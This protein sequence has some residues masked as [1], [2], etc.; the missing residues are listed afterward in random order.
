MGPMVDY[1]RESAWVTTM[2]KSMPKQWYMDSACTR[3]MTPNRSIFKTFDPT[4]VRPIELADGTEI[5]SAG[6]GIIHATLLKSANG[7]KL[8]LKNV[9]YVPDLSSNLIS[10]SQLELLGI[11]THF[12]LGGKLDILRGGERIGMG[13]RT[14]KSYPLEEVYPSAERVF[15]IREKPVATPNEK[16]LSDLDYKELIHRRLGHIGR[17]R[18][19][20]LHSHVDGL[21]PINLAL[22]HNHHCGTCPRT[23]LVRV[24]NRKSP[25]KATRKLG[26]VHMDFG[27]LYYLESL[28]GFRYM[29]IL[30]D[31]ATGKSW[32]FLCKTRDEVYNKIK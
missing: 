4:V 6:M 15:K 7:E 24:I 25:E 26:R 30:T 19:T 23:R 10:V 3:H 1:E 29:L 16:Q 27:G 17:T 13:M 22:P 32:V 31:E 18:L 20:T 2:S 12:K 5:R 28:G 21:R 11:E 9:L 14:G 8:R